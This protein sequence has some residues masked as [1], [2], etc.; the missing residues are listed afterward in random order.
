[1]FS[2][3]QSPR[4]TTPKQ[5]SDVAFYAS[6]D[7]KIGKAS[8]TQSKSFTKGKRKMFHAFSLTDNPCEEL[9]HNVPL[10]N[11]RQ[12]KSLS[13]GP[14]NRLPKALTAQRSAESSP[15]GKVSSLTRLSSYN[16]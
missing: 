16:D 4:F 5:N 2:I 1:M 13:S 8:V 10:S 14:P 12:T 3:G 15:S 9:Y 6:T 7:N 11:V